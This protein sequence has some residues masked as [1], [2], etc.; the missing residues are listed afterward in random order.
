M[1]VYLPLSHCPSPS[2]I[3]LRSRVFLRSS[4]SCFAELEVVWKG[5][6]GLRVSKVALQILAVPTLLSLPLFLPLSCS[7]CCVNLYIVYLSIE[8]AAF[9]R[10]CLLSSDL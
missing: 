1:S 3:V 7:A 4:S 9:S 8:F 6:R 10:I 2:L 5:E